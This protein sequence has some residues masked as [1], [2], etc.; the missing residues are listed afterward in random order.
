MTSRRTQLLMFAAAAFISLLLPATASAQTGPW[1]GRDRNR[2]DDRYGRGYGRISDNER[3]VL[4]D[5]SRRIDDRSR[6]FQRNIDSALDNSRIDDTRREDR[7]NEQVADFRRAAQRFRD[8]AGDSN[9]LSRS[10]SEARELLNQGSRIDRV[11]GRARLNS[12]AGSDW[13]QIRSDL[14]TVANIYN[15]N[16][17]DFGGG[18]GRDDDNYGRDRDRNR[19]RNDNRWPRN[20]PF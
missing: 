15:V 10:M 4:R 12:R 17:R 6:S 11:I 14:R 3:R 8:R 2:D 13:S 16:T 20:W 5:V 18:W 9:D 19:D 7:I 1:W